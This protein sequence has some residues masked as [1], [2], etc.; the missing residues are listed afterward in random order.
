MPGGHG[1]L[2][3]A[4]PVQW[5]MALPAQIA[6]RGRACAGR[7]RWRLGGSTITRCRHGEPAAM[8]GGTRQGGGVAELT[9]RQRIEWAA[10]MA[11]C[12]VLHGGH[13]G[14]VASSDARAVLQLKDGEGVKWGR[15]I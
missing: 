4:G 1:G 3:L 12:D 15:S 5:D 14:V 13:N 2:P 10:K 8:C 11:R 9:G 6:R 7:A